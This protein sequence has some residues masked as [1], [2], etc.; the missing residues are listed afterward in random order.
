[1]NNKRYRSKIT[2]HI[3]LTFSQFCVSKLIH[4]K[5]LIIVSSSNSNKKFND[6]H[7]NFVNPKAVITKVVDIMVPKKD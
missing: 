7:L 1:M 2:K 5:Y 6:N 4:I 3:V